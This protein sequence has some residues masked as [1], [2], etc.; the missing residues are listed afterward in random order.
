M[1]GSYAKRGENFLFRVSDLK[2]VKV[3]LPPLFF[4]R[5]GGAWS[6]AG[7]LW[8]KKG[9]TWNRVFAH[10]FHCVL[11]IEDAMSFF[12]FSTSAGWE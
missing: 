10:L 4:M 6:D 9:H 1:R 8:G 3:R 2:Y 5:S 12:H 11:M 7:V